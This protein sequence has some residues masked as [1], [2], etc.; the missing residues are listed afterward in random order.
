MKNVRSVEMRATKFKTGENNPHIGKLKKF[1]FNFTVIQQSG[2]EESY[3]IP[4]QQQ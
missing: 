3:R 1:E 2:E 4:A